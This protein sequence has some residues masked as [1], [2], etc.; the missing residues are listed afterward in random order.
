[1]AKGMQSNLMCSQN[2][3]I[4][5]LIVYTVEHQSRVIK[6]PAKQANEKFIVT[7]HSFR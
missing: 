2:T 4:H 5:L 3:D 6:S 1:M 7:K